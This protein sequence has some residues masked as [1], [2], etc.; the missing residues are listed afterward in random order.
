MKPFLMGMFDQIIIPS[1]IVKIYVQKVVK[2]K[3]GDVPNSSVNKITYI[4]NFFN[5]FE[6][7]NA[8]LNSFKFA[9]VS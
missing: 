6:F 2:K 9:S 5:I 3:L 4:V 8:V 1:K 7:A